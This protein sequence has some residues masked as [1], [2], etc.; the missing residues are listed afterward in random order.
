MERSEGLRILGV[1]TAAYPS[2]RPT[3]ETLELYI[4]VLAPLPAS[5]V[6]EVVMARMHTDAEFAPPVGVLFKAAAQLTLA[7]SSRPTIT[8]EEAWELVGL[9]IRERGYYEGPGEL[10]GSLAARRAVDAIGW[11]T[12]CT[13]ENIEATRAHFMRLFASFQEREIQ[14]AVDCLRSERELPGRDAAKPI[15]HHMTLPA[16]DAIEPSRGAALMGELV[17]KIS[18]E[19][20]A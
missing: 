19:L 17:A 1:L 5:L 4:R 3:E 2:W 20:P 6:K 7:A 11:P 16:P 9:A 14:A 10:A 13:N 8:A 18:K 12:I 15:A